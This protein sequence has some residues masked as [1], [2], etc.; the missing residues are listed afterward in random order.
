MTTPSLNPIIFEAPLANPSPN[1][2]FA[3]TTW[4]D[5]TI[6]R[7]LASGVQVRLHNYGGADAFGVLADWCVSPDDLEPEDIKT[8]TRP[9]VPDPFD[10][11]TSWAFDTCDMTEPS[12]AE[13]R[14]RVQQNFR[15]V[16]QVAVEREFAARLIADAPPGPTPGTIVAAVGQLEAELA[17][18]NT[19]GFIHASA[20][21]VAAA[22]A[23]NLIVRS[24]STLKT[25]LGHLWV[26]GGGYVDGLGK[27]LVA[28]SPTFGW[29]DTVAV[30][31]TFAPRES[32]YLAIAE[33]S[34][35]VGYEQAIGTAGLV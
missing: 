25:P 2:L 7:W 35:V 26:F 20:G 4:T 1:G 11:I 3:A 28:T 10:P 13:V 27:A 9:D 29:R 12:Q 17:K 24:G 14:T 16:E 34:A 33:R 21:V 18:T 8:G 23:A 15:L 30:R 19:V 6:P 31:D 5:D 32:E 22:T